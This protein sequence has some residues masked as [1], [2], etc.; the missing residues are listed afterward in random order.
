[1]KKRLYLLNTLAAALLF[2]GCMGYQLGGSSLEGIDSVTMGPVINSSGEPAIEL[3]VT[4]ALR[5]RIHF[6]GR[7]KLINESKNADAIIDITLTEYSLKP[8]AFSSEQSATPDLYRLRITAEAELRSVATGEV[9][10]TSHTYGEQTVDF[11]DDLTSAK[12]DAL[13]LAAD[14]LSRFILD[15]LIEAWQ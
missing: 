14:K 13:P 8:I 4:H 1:M 6:D 2:S 5:E 9:L 3:Q 15:D 11:Q 12:R 10:S 7:M